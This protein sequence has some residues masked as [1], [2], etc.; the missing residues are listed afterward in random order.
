MRRALFVTAVVRKMNLY[1]EK[2]IAPTNVTTSRSLAPNTSHATRSPSSSTA[3]AGHSSSLQTQTRQRHAQ[4]TRRCHNPWHGAP[5][6][7]PTASVPQKPAEKLPEHCPLPPR[8][9]R[10]LLSP[11]CSHLPFSLPRKRR[12]EISEKVHP[13]RNTTRMRRKD[14]LEALSSLVVPAAEIRAALALH[15]A[16]SARPP[17]PGWPRACERTCEGQVAA[18]EQPH[19]LVQALPA[20]P[21]QHLGR[22]TCE[23]QA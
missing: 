16:S 2:S 17:H 4:G 5:C 12:A 22:H 14:S 19:H 7:S 3:P 18:V 8:S 23:S 13:P 11:F 15:P 20:P 21:L 9:H 6:S 10:G 1:P